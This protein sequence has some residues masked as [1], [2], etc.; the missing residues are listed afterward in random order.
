M[1]LG[2]PA[3]RRA[4]SRGHGGPCTDVWKGDALVPPPLPPRGAACSEL[5]VLSQADIWRLPRGL[6]KRACPLNSVPMQFSAQNRRW[7]KAATCSCMCWE[8]HSVRFHRGCMQPC[9]GAAVGGTYSE[10][11]M[12]SFFSEKR[13]GSQRLL[14]N[15]HKC[16]T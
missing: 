6:R 5:G 14:Y 4:C 1:R 2:G 8:V 10:R 9:S 15:V 12:S 13:Y 3:H 16:C 11:Q 7:K